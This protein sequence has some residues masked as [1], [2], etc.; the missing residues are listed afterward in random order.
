[1][2]RRRAACGAGLRRRPHVTSPLRV[3]HLE[4]DVL[5]AEFVQAALE[6]D[7]LVVE[8][9]RVE[10]EGDFR[11]ALAQCFDVILAD[12][13]LSAFDALSALQLTM[14][15]CPQVPFILVSK[16]LGEEVAIEALK[17]GAT[18]CVLKNRLSRIGPSVQRALRETEGR[19]ERE[20]AEAMLAGE[21]QLLGMI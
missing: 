20:R 12:N 18:D 9:T 1:T 13:A 14:E 16:T 5:A 3:L 15:V 8:V 6:G 2:S 11:A 7:G 17:R 4:D 21:K 10:T 19:R